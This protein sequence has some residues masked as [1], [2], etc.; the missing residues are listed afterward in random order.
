MFSQESLEP[1]IEHTKSCEGGSESSAATAFD[2]SKAKLLI[3]V[4]SRALCDDPRFTFVIP[5]QEIRATVLPRFFAS[6][7]RASELYGERLIAPSADGAIWLRP[8]KLQAINARCDAN[9][10]DCRSSYERFTFRVA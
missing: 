5:D 9:C 10:S 2:T 8:V 1:N 7:I 3:Q 6:A 4:L